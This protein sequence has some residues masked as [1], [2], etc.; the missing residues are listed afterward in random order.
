MFQY[1]MMAYVLENQRADKKSIFHF[2]LQFFVHQGFT[3]APSQPDL[4]EKERSVTLLLN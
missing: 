4:T 1:I 2:L 3:S